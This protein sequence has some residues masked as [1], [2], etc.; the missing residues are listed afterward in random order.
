MYA[1]R[2]NFRIYAFNLVIWS[3]NY[4]LY[5]IITFKCTRMLMCVYTVCN[6]MC[7]CVIVET[8]TS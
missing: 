6:I 2:S 7:T 4:K 1:S 3:H 8:S 5:M